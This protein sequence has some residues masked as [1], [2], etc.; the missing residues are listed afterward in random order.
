MQEVFEA[1]TRSQFDDIE[2]RP[3]LVASLSAMQF[4]AIPLEPGIQTSLIKKLLATLH[5]CS[6]DPH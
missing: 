6:A 4:S 3:L 5:D 1:R 2:V